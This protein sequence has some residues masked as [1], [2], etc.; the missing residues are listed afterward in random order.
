VAAEAILKLYNSYNASHPTYR[1]RAEVGQA[2]KSIFLRDYL[3]SRKAQQEIHEGLNVV[4]NWNAT[5]PTKVYKHT[6]VLLAVTPATKG[7][8]L[9]QA[10]PRRPRGTP[11]DI[12]R[13][14]APM[15]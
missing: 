7:K 9:S 8:R 5:N 3:R 11:R 4:E 13:S 10:S 12:S 15:A 1:A 14:R 6:R 2:E